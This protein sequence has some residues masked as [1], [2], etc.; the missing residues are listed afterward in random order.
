MLVAIIITL[1]VLALLDLTVI[2]PSLIIAG[3]ADRN[4]INE[5]EMM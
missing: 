3:E 5:K 4:F 1:A 2:F